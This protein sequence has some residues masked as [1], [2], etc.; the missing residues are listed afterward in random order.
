M[1]IGRNGKTGLAGHH[2]I[3][4]SIVIR[5]EIE[6]RIDGASPL[7]R[8]AYCSQFGVRFFLLTNIIHAVFIG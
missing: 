2:F 4:A 6:H 1:G 8:I 7:G 5:V 3:L